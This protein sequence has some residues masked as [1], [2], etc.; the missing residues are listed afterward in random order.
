MA[1][2]DLTPTE[3]KALDVIVDY[4]RKTKDTA[5]SVTGWG[6]PRPGAGRKPTGRSKH[7]YYI[8]EAED[9]QLREY[10]SSLRK[11]D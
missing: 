2:D 6:G 3:E 4:T 10:L 8:T 9:K 7:L 5:L 11:P 1:N